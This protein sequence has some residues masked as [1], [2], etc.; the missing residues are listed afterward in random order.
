MGTTPAGTGTVLI[1]GGGTGGHVYPALAV[2]SELARRGLSPVFVG[3]E[4]G[5]EARLVPQHGFPLE[6]LRVQGIRG[7]GLRG[8]A[9]AL[10]LPIAALDALAILRRHAPRAV[11]GVGG[12]A[13]GPLVALA[14]LLRI[15]SMIEEQNV[16]PG[17]TNRLLARFV[18]DVAL[19]SEEARASFGG[20]GFVAGVPVR[21][22]FFAE[23][24]KAPA[25]CG[26]SSSAAARG[27][28]C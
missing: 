3:T 22:E 14:A 23:K 9:A 8:L 19:P 25:C 26:S 27:R 4:R 10:R 24:K 2:G 13:S 11:L 15:P 1:A 6:L 20:R 5:L 7:R 12:Y 16:A 18:R 21:P 17:A 28:A